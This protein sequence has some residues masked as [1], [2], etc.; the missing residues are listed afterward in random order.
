[1]LKKTAVLLSALWITSSAGWATPNDLGSTNFPTSGSPEAQEHFLEGLLALHSFEYRDARDAFRKAR[2]VE[3]DFAMAAWGEA[4]TYNHPLWLEEDR[5]SALEALAELAPTREERL[6]KAPTA[7]EKGYL[8]AVEILFGDGDKLARDLAY[9]EATQRLMEAYPDDLDAASFHALALLGTCHDGRDTATYMKA[10]AIVEQVFAKNP[11]HP[12]AAHYLIHSYDDPVHA[13]LGLRPAKVYAEIAPA[14]E[15]ALHMPS[16]VFLALGMWEETAASNV[17]SYQAGEARRERKDLGVEARGY[18]AMLW[19]FYANLQLGRFEEAREQLDLIAADNEVTDS[20]RTRRHFA[21]MRASWVVET[22]RGD[23]LPPGP[24]LDGLSPGSVASDL[25][26]TGYAAVL[27][28]EIDEAERIKGELV[29]RY[30]AAAHEEDQETVS[31]EGYSRFGP[32]RLVGPRIMELELE[33]MIHDARGQRDRAL[34]LLAEAAAA[35]ETRSFGFGP[36]SPAKPAHELYG[37]MLLAA[38]RPDD[39]RRQFEIA[40]ERAP[41][42]AKSLQGLVAAARQAGDEVAA[43]KTAAVLASIRRGDDPAP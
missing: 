38:G 26:A 24:D 2:E 34:E 9:A 18:H 7:R 28:G 12:G 5:D 36:P 23:D 11:M 21:Q 8:E 37:E 10:A 40:L 19:L 42:R 20:R 1:M 25:F 16:H 27:R 3:P 15:H 22:G 33:A 32:V 6:A 17:D 30:H 29:E 39:A 14:A 4:M 31:C 13:P 35:E 41:K 43:E